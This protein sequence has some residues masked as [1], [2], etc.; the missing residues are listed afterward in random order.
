[1]RKLSIDRFEGQYAL[2]EDNE[3]KMFAIEINELPEGARPSDILI[4]SDDGVLSVDK[5]GTA[6]Q[7]KK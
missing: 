5:E 3:G 6:N 2:C 4:I 1:M 7:K